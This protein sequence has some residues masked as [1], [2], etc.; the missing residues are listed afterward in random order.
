MIGLNPTDS[1]PVLE[2]HYEEKQVLL[3]HPH[4]GQDDIIIASDIV[5]EGFR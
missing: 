2:L 3:P 4:I 1:L 5:K